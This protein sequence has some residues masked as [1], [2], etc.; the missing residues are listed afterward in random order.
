MSGGFR[1]GEI[2]GI[3]IRLHW[4]L[5]LFGA[6]VAFTSGG[7]ALGALLSALLLFGSIVLHELGHALVARGYG[8]ATRDIVLTPIGG[9]ARIE[10]MPRS[11]RAEVA[12]ALAGPIVSLAIAG[13]SFGALSLLPMKGIAVGLLSTLGWTNGMLGLFNL[14]P[15]FP[16][17][18]GRVL[19]GALASR[20]GL[21]R[22]TEVAASVGRVAAIAMGLVGLAVGNPS[23]V[24]VAVFVWMAGGR[25]R[26]MVMAER[27]PRA[28]DVLGR[29]VEVELVEPIRP[30]PRRP[31]VVYRY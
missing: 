23:L 22:A 6:F 3:P 13:L 20:V 26:A 17:D 19:R 18:G 24:L 5:L 7:G 12:I 21:V 29:P 31:L 28:W 25:E 2:A 8:I 16:L 15:A 4:S 1:I 10:G 9:I 27:Q 30:A 14:I 11:G